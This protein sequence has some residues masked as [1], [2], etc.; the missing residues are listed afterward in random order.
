[1]PAFAEGAD[2]HGQLETLLSRASHGYHP[3]PILQRQ[4]NWSQAPPN[5]GD[6]FW[7]LKSWSDGTDCIAKGRTVSQQLDNCWD[8]N[9]RAPIVLTMISYTKPNQ[10]LPCRSTRTWMRVS[11]YL[12]P[13]RTTSQNTVLTEISWYN[14]I[15]LQKDQ[16]NL[17]IIGKRQSNGRHREHNEW[18]S[19]ELKQNNRQRKLNY[20]IAQ[21]WNQIVKSSHQSHQ[22]TAEV[23]M[24]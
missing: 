22:L 15:S 7:Y 8:I 17:T 2:D 14:F 13:A 18:C 1:M 4:R 3:Q 24:S 23:E 6:T 19:D 20:Q 16:K 11:C 9:S 5:D 21:I 10:S 12:V